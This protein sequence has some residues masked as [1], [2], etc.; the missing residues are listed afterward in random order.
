MSPKMI[1]MLGFIIGS[2]IGGYVPVLFGAS[3]LSY[4]SLAGNTIGGIIGIYIAYKSVF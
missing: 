1:V 4:A 2:T 3:L